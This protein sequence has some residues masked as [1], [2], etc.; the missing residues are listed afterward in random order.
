MIR[1]RVKDECSLSHALF[2]FLHERNLLPEMISGCFVSLLCTPQANVRQTLQATLSA[3][4]QAQKRLPGLARRHV[5]HA[6]C[7]YCNEYFS[8]DIDKVVSK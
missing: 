8:K 4:T 3:H 1:R 7:L 6:D 5:L 2:L